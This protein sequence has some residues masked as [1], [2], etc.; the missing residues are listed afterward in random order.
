MNNNNNTDWKAKSCSWSLQIFVRQID[1]FR[2]N[3]WGWM[4]LA[5]LCIKHSTVE[6]CFVAKPSSSFSSTAYDYIMNVIHLLSFYFRKQWLWVYLSCHR[7][8]HWDYSIQARFWMSHYWALLCMPIL[9]RRLV[10]YCP[11]KKR[12]AGIN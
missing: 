11:N 12:N 9:C 1:F 4:Y 7:Q 2:N 6:Q 8:C 10:P 5:Q 3:C